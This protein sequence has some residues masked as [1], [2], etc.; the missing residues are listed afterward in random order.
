M[1][2]E[3]M[4]ELEAWQESTIVALVSQREEITNR[5]NQAI[6]RVNMAIEQNAK[7]WSDGADGNLGFERRGETFVLVRIVQ[8]DETGMAPTA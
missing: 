2:N 1:P 5:A 4:K 8:D 7:L 3:I 6:A